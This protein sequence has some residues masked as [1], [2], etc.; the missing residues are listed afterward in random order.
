MRIFPAV[1]AEQPCS[2]VGSPILRR[3]DHNRSKDPREKRDTAP[4]AI[5]SNSDHVLAFEPNASKHRNNDDPDRLA[6]SL[7]PEVTGEDNFER[8]QKCLRALHDEIGSLPRAA[9]L[10]PTPGLPRVE[11][12]AIESRWIGPGS[13]KRTRRGLSFLTK[14]LIASA[15]VGSA[16]YIFTTESLTQKADEFVVPASIYQIGG[17]FPRVLPALQPMSA[18]EGVPARGDN[19]REAAVDEIAVPPQDVRGLEDSARVRETS[20]AENSPPAD[21][22]PPVHAAIAFAASDTK[23][24]IDRGTQFLEAGDVA[25]ARLLFNRAANAGDAVAAVAMGK[26]Y[27]PALLADREVRGMGDPE[28]ARTWYEKAAAM[29]SPEALRLLRAL[30]GGAAPALQTADQVPASETPM[31]SRRSISI[32]KHRNVL[33]PRW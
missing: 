18:A 32:R 26:T 4:S 9:Q 5:S 21:P 31:P 7:K 1:L 22:T 27:D 17:G 8:L 10:A 20:I 12:G 16:A 28:K 14:S 3:A 23:P 15:V 29:G 2:T 24:L 30:D 13:P 11:A 33:Q 19:D 6:T 25:A